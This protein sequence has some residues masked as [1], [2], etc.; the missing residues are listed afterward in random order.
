MDEE[1]FGDNCK[2]IDPCLVDELPPCETKV[3]VLAWN[4]TDEKDTLRTNEVD[5]NDL[6]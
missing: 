2:G 3:R 4:S 5:A 1:L 6:H